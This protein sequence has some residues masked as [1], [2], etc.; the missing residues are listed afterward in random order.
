MSDNKISCKNLN[1]YAGYS[2][3]MKFAINGEWW[4][5]QTVT[6]VETYKHVF[7]DSP[8]VKVKNAENF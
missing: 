2:P 4:T 7:T 1:Y 6:E 3:E 5:L 8:S